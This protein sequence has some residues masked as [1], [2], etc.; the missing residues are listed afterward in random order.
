VVRRLLVIIVAL[1]MPARAFADDHP[2]IAA[3]ADWEYATIAAPHPA[4][5]MGARTMI[6]LDAVRAQREHPITD[7][8]HEEIDALSGAAPALGPAPHWL[9]AAPAPF[10]LAGDHPH[11][12]TKLRLGAHVAR[13]GALLVRRTFHVGDELSRVQVL[14]LR[15]RYRD[16]LIVRVNDVEVARRN[17]RDAA[18]T[19]DP[20]VRTH[21]PEWET[22]YIPVTSGLLKDGDNVLTL[23][24]HPGP[25]RLAPWIDA[26]LSGA[27]AARIVRGPLVQRVEGATATI[28]VE[29]DLPT[30]AD[31]LF[32][33][34]AAAYDRRAT[35]DVESTRHV[36]TLSGLYADREIHY[37][38]VTSG[39]T[40]TDDAAFHTAP[41]DDEPVRFVVYG[42]V[43]SG[44]AVH[45]KLLARITE[46]APDFIVSTGDMVLRGSDEADWQKFF[47][48]AGPTLARIPMYPVIGNHDRVTGDR[49]RFDDIF[50]LPPAP[51]GRPDGAAWYSFD[52][53]GVHFAM[54][55]SN[56]FDD[57]RQL[58]WLDADLTA[59]RAHGARAIFAA[60]HHGPWS[61]GPH[62]GDERCAKLY[63]PILEKHGVAVV[64]SGHDHL[65]QRGQ[66][67]NLAYVVS[68]GGGAGLYAPRCGVEGRPRCTADG[69]KKIASEHHYVAL[70]VFRDYVRMCPKRAD[71]TAIEACVD[72]SLPEG[73][74]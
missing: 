62:G 46:E 29:T 54:I 16:G 68:G 51:D 41:G 43:R 36:I 4:E 58:A 8:P 17:L 52:V 27:E 69:T 49:R 37:Q 20:A 56:R 21:G 32:G 24:V 60:M 70:E 5:E 15:A 13:L 25:Q 30:R 64:F 48:I 35:D 11:A 9:S 33:E 10:G 65:Y 66:V 73:S 40:R 26:E 28:V 2:Y 55:D 45:G 14:M 31:V 7:A 61:L 72:V 57:A 50:D 63:A 38:I 6:V 1:A 39:G 18:T 74:N 59:A 44:H 23:E 42:D 67:G 22:I 3:G 47:T 34:A 19:I 71:G 12:V 53:A